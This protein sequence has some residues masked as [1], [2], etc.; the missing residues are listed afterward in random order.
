MRQRE[1]ADA[2]AAE[3]RIDRPSPH[4]EKFASLHRKRPVVRSHWRQRCFSLRRPRETAVR[5][6]PLFR[7]RDR[8][9]AAQQTDAKG[10]IR[11]RADAEDSSI[12]G[13]PSARLPL[14]V[15]IESDTITTN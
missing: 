8:I 13:C 7:S 9:S 2:A 11:P 12:A 4:G 1:D 3:N 10:H 15:L 14:I 6:F 5:Q